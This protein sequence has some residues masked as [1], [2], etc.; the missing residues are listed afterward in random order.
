MKLRTRLDVFTAALLSALGATQVVA[1]G[2]SALLS[3]GD[4]A[5]SGA[6][7]ANVGGANVGGAS[8]GGA[9]AAGDGQ[10]GAASAGA[11][12]NVGGGA[13][14]NK[15]PCTDPQALSHGFEQ[16]DGFKHRQK[17]ETCISLVPRPD[18]VPNPDIGECKF[19][20]DC[21]E[22]PYGWCDSGGQISTTYCSYGCVID[23]DCGKNQL[24]ECGEPVGRCVQ[25][26]CTSDADC[27]SGFLCKR[28]DMS[29]GCDHTVYSCQSPADSC[30]RDADCGDGTCRLGADKQRFE[31]HTDRC[32]IGRPFLVEG[33]QRVAPMTARADWSEFALLPKFAKLDAAL[34]ARLAEEWTSVGLMEHA[35]IAAFARFTLQ[36]LSLGAPASLIERATN[37]MLD[38]TKHA[39]ACFAVASGYAGAPLGPGRLAVER[40]LDESSLEEIVLNT[41]REGCVGETVAAIEA[42]EAAE[43]ASDPALR[44]LL[45]MISADETR[46][47]Q[48][49]Y[50]F[51][52]WALVLGGPQLERVVRHEFTRFGAEMP[53]V[54]GAATDTDGDLLRH[55]IVPPAMRQAIRRQAIAQVILPCSRELF[56]RQRQTGPRLTSESV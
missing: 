20:A 14:T 37:A 2:G 43:N 35:S 31:C 19:D 30:G 17:Q 16:C 42:H 39:Q 40:S 26:D 52:K 33:A 54:R 12:V 41:I 47:A 7:R 51:V 34:A 32:Y 48:L 25:A 55:G 22:R 36:L 18:A 5:G 27:Q 11:P 21:K 28:Y 50:Q 6:G 56:A 24:C 38:E 29:S 8:V 49:A 9:S 46:H 10:S 53:L 4:A 23:E 13:A 45:L 1:C 15:F 3:G 44:E